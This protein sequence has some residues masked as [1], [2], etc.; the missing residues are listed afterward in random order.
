VKNACEYNTR[1][2]DGRKCGLRAHTW[3]CRR[4]FLDSSGNSA[5]RLL[6][7]A[8]EAREGVDALHVFK[9]QAVQSSFE[10]AAGESG[11]IEFLQLYTMQVGDVEIFESMSDMCRMQCF[12][13]MTRVAF[14][15]GDVIMK[16]GTL[17][18]AIYF[19]QD[20]KATEEGRVTS[21]GRE[22]F[23]EY[24][25]GDFFGEKA[26]VATARKAFGIPSVST[27]EWTNTTF[28]SKG[29][30]CW[31][32]DAKDFVRVISSNL[33]RTQEVLRMLSKKSEERLKGRKRLQFDALDSSSSSSTD[34]DMD[35]GETLW[36]ATAEASPCTPSLNE[37][38]ED[39]DFGA[40]IQVLPGRL[41]FTVHRDEAETRMAILHD[42]ETY[43][44]SS[45]LHETYEPYCDDFGPVDLATVFTFC[46]LLQDKLSDE[47]LSGRL[48]CYYAEKD[49]KLRTNAAFL[50]GAFLI[51]VEAFS[52]AEVMA[53]LAA[54]GKYAFMPF[55]DA[56][57]VQPSTFNLSLLD[58][59]KGLQR[60][61]AA[62]W[63]DLATFDVH[64][65]NRLARPEG[66]DMHQICPKF[67][68]FRGP[69]SRD[70]K[71][72]RPRDYIDIFWHLGVTAVVRLNG[73]E[74]YDAA[75]FE[76][77]G[78][79]VYNLEF[80]DCT[81]P[82]TSI[83]ER[84]L[85]VVDQ[86]Q[87]IVAVHCLAGLGRT[88]TLISLWIMKNMGWTAR[89]CIAWL[90]IVRPGSVL[91]LQQHYLVDCERALARNLPLPEPAAVE[92]AYSRV[93]A[94][95]LAKQVERGM[96]RRRN[97]AA[98]SLGVLPKS[99]RHGNTI[100]EGERA[101]IAQLEDSNAV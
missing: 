91:G 10:E 84:F 81:A 39:L 22:S 68:A 38:E 90:R 93:R 14:D 95:R 45:E 75:E 8:R 94:A 97:N 60:A 55:R 2:A 79:R 62:R 87:G 48:I 33:T 1:S 4:T 74:T 54:A 96:L 23:H 35:R 86:T 59:F 36:E 17:G 88:G 5:C 49:I 46:N 21:E 12:G 58:C 72:H 52:P 51:Q 92:K 31:R 53:L 41:A 6:T 63:F 65:Y 13:S 7:T 89:E 82:P 78:I 77:G 64:K 29:C 44:F 16:R 24:R 19:V 57:H 20:G 34:D 42:R 37:M 18:D 25:K 61:W 27:A 32:L 99:E 101:L 71:G 80:E 28:V 15:D 43:Y 98:P 70:K 26:F 100:T 73:V 40:L 50:I 3:V 47:R 56:T 66:F 83:V 11:L 9:S 69:N 67:V 30:V 76:K 85:E